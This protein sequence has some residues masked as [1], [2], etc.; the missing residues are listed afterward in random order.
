MKGTPLIAYLMYDTQ[1]YTVLIRRIAVHP[2]YRR[3]GHATSLL[4][5]ILKVYIKT[6]IRVPITTRPHYTAAPRK[7]PEPSPAIA[8]SGHTL[9]RKPTTGGPRRGPTASI[10]INQRLY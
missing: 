4:R 7:R 6:L 10:R 5:A 2:D 1:P 3:T 8:L 9:A